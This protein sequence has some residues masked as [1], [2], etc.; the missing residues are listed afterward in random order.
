MLAAAQELLITAGLDGLSM[1]ALARQLSVTP[2]ALYSH[3][4][5]KTALL[6]DLCDAVLAAVEVPVPDAADPA[7]GVRTLMTSSYD[8]LCRHPALVPVFLVRQGARGPH[9]VALGE[10]LDALLVRLGLEGAAVGEARRVLIVHAI[11]FA[12]FATSPASSG[13]DGRPADPGAARRTFTTSLRWLLDG[14]SRRAPA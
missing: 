5:N 2:N 3:V 12:A 14:I 9:A 1:R 13:A 8:V 4:A 11:G 7:D 10:V 6:D